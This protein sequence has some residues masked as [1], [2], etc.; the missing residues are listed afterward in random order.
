M[1]FCLLLGMLVTGEVIGHEAEVHVLQIL[2][3]ASA[4]PVPLLQ[5]LDFE[6]LQKAHSSS[7]LA[8]L[9]EQ[10]LQQGFGSACICM[11]DSCLAMS[12]SQLFQCVSETLA[13]SRADMSQC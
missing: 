11:L 5:I 7:S 12:C 3:T 13:G 1:A 4:L 10:H 2:C 6:G 9:H 8:A